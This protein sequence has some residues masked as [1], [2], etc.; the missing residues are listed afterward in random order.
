MYNPFSLENKTI[1]IT[2]AS[3][4][5]GKATALECARMGAKVII[6]GRNEGRLNETFS[7]LEGSGHRIIVATLENEEGI[8]LLVAGLPELNGIVN[9]AGMLKIV[10]FQFINRDAINEI[11]NLN[12]F[13]PVLLSQKIIK[14]KKLVK[15]SSVVF[16][17]SIDGTHTTHIGNSIYSSTKGALC[18]IVR[19]MALELAS[20]KIRVNSVLPGMIQ[21]PMINFENLSEEQKQ[22]ELKLYPLK[23]F[24]E[25][26]EVAHSI[27]Y[28]LS[29][30]SSWVTGT[31]MVIDGGYTLL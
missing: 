29:D 14:S 12:F 16:V 27:I 2:G 30:A 20:K 28:L 18:S 6:T 13:S 21:T 31:G 7:A 25:P 17:S 15:Q 19:S 22:S 26:V 23:R 8:D 5:I 24:G 1:L 9:A 10:P 11:F 3:S 4:G